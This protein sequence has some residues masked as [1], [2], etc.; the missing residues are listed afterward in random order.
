MTLARYPNINSGLWQ[1]LSAGKVSDK[2][3]SFNF[4]TDRC[5]I[6]IDIILR[7]AMKHVRMYV[8]IH[9]PS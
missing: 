9:P 5:G 1:W 6:I 2:Q 7:S 4:D 8:C 3:K